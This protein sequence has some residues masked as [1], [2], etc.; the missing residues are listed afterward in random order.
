MPTPSPFG[1]EN[2]PPHLTSFLAI[3]LF[4][5]HSSSGG[6][7]CFRFVQMYDLALNKIKTPCFP[8]FAPKQVRDFYNIRCLRMDFDNELGLLRSLRSS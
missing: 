3:P 1:A 7:A 4:N 5:L 8:S 6:S 2:I